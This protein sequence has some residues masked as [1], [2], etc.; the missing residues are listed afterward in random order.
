MNGSVNELRTKN[1][2]CPWCRSTSIVVI[3]STDMV[4]QCAGCGAK[5]PTWAK[6]ADEAVAAWNNRSPQIDVAAAAA[7]LSHHIDHFWGG[8]VKVE[9][10]ADAAKACLEAG[11]S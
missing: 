9:R 2:P 11:L 1:K 4:V 6:T 10:M 7:A 3:L 5:I 8:A